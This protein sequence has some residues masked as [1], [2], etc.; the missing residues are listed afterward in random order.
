ML[1][2]VVRIAMETAMRKAEI[3]GLYR[4]DVD[5]Q[6]RVAHVSKIGLRAP[7]KT[8]LT[9][10]AVQ[11]FKA[12]LNQVNVTKDTSLIFFGDPG[13]FGTRRPYAIDKVFRHAVMS[14][15]LKA[16]RF[17][18]LRFDAISRMRES[19]LTEPEVA[20]IVGL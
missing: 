19:G 1:G 14:A 9:R 2:W 7:R 6:S 20:A 17:D 3:L 16:F 13:K 18:D 8:P 5:L 15:R 12:A 11:A 10:V 4:R